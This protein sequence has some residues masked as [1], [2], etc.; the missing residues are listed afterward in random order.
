MD[1]NTKRDPLIQPEYGRC[2]QEMVDY[3]KSIQDREERQ[4][5]ANTIVALMANIQSNRQ[6][7]GENMTS[8][9][10]NHI[11]AMSGYSLDIDY[12]VEI[13]QP[14]D[15]EKLA[16][17]LPYPNHKIS[18]RHYGHILE[19]LIQKITETEDAEER[20]K[21]TYVVANQMKRSLASWNRDAMDNEKIMDDLARYSDGKIQ[22]DPENFDFISDE[23]AIAESQ[24]TTTSGKKKKKK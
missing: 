4:R 13:K 3:A 5:C 17:H 6:D 24:P 1:Y 21:L 16:K 9:L 11:A 22:I 18:K 7:S 19:S 20:D 12:P 2:I 8:K 14:E 10:W 15:K 23:K